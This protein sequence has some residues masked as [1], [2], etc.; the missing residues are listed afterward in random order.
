MY[1]NMK[2]IVCF[3]LIF[4]TLGITSFAQNTVLSKKEIRQ[5]ERIKRKEEAEKAKLKSIRLT[6]HLIEDQRYVLLADEL[7]NQYGAR[8]YV[9]HMINFIVVDSTHAVIQTGNDFS[10][11]ANGVGGFTIKGKISK[12]QMTK[13]EKKGTYQISF[14]VNSSTGTYDVNLHF[15]NTGSGRA[16]V[17]SATLPGRI[18]FYGDI[19]AVGKRKIFKGNSL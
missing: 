8:A 4:T 14:W 12:Y 11:G 1:L 6:D 19:E 18:T 10:L 3:I 7:S 5:M 17:S 2:K 13:N 16:T 9:N 15:F